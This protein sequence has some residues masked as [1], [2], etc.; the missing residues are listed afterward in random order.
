VPSPDREACR[1]PAR[2]RADGAAHLGLL[3]RGDREEVN[4]L[5]QRAHEP[6]GDLLRA[7]L[8]DQAAARLRVDLLL[9]PTQPGLELVAR[10]ASFEPVVVDQ[11]PAGG[12][13]GRSC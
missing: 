13:A 2:K 8:P 3:V 7:A 11:P 10:K 12:A 6:A 9:E 4:V 1:E 5:G